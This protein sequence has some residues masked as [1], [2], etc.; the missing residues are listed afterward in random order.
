MNTT[1]IQGISLIA[2]MISLPFLSWGIS[3]GTVVLT[4]IGAVLLTAGMV[5]LTVLR[6][7]KTKE[8]T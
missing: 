8:K 2:M 6:Y 4:L 5:M 1:V 3:S 7:V